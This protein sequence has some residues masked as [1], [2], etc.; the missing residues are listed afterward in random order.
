MA[1]NDLSKL[2]DIMFNQI[3]RLDQMSIKDPEAMASEIERA[4][5]IK[6]LASTVI[7]NG[8]LVLAAVQT[9]SEVGEAVCVPRMLG[10]GNE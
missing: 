2:N 4:K 1:N 3:D 7:D 8:R 5:V 9:S 10:A 6:S